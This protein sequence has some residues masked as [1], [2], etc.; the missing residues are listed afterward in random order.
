[1]K[2][3]FEKFLKT[4]N[5]RYIISLILGLGLASFF[6]YICKEKECLDFIGPPVTEIK[7]KIYK[8]GDKCYKYIPRATECSANK[9]IINFSNNA[10]LI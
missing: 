6:R 4:P 9:K 8:N 3:F 5:G 2:V 10:S 1:M 7:D